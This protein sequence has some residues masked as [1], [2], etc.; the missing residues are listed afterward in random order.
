MKRKLILSILII[1]IALEAEYFVELWIYNELPPLASTTL[2]LAYLSFLTQ[3]FIQLLLICS[4]NVFIIS[5]LE[6]KLPWGEHFI[7]RSTI[8]FTA[9]TIV[10]VIITTPVVLYIDH[11]FLTPL[12]QFPSDGQ[13]I[14]LYYNLLYISVIN[15]LFIVTYEVVFLFGERN[16]IKLESEQSRNRAILA[17]FDA[18]RNQV[19][20]HFL[21]NS[22]HTLMELIKDDPTKAEGFCE[23][24][25]NLYRRALT[26]DSE[27]VIPIQE[28]IRFAKSYI[29]LYKVQ[30]GNHIKVD[31]EIDNNM[32]DAVPPF[33][34][35]LLIENAFKH[36]E[37]SEAK[38]LAIK[39]LAS[40]GYLKVIN[41]INP[42]T[43]Q[44]NSTKV[45]L[46][47]LRERYKLLGTKEVIIESTESEFIASI[48][49]L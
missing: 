23:E 45:G 2:V 7:L 25:I 22:M 33:S 42:K 20:P 10:A 47:N 46:T 37:I 34:L 11:G 39:I 28:E 31:F 19:N 41:N 43:T 6:K 16:K 48:P 44:I 3:T 38:P 5:L 49:I 36:N 17:Q 13:A 1:S 26:V 15:A 30:Y 18:L 14:T 12:F 29:S 27:A 32:K 21:L 4:I 40:N 24:F 8:E 35:Q 9:T